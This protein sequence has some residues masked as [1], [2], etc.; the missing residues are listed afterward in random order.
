MGFENLHVTREPRFGNEAVAEVV[1]RRYEEG[2]IDLKK[3]MA[4]KERACGKCLH[5]M[6]GMGKCIRV[7]WSGRGKQTMMGMRMNKERKPTDMM[8]SRP[9]TPSSQ[10]EAQRNESRGE[11]RRTFSA[12]NDPPASPSPHS[13]VAQTL[14]TADEAGMQKHTPDTATLIPVPLTKQQQREL[15]A[16]KKAEKRRLALANSLNLEA[17]E[18]M[19]KFK[20]KLKKETESE[21]Q[22]R[23]KEEAEAA[24]RAEAAAKVKAEKE[25]KAKAEAMA[26]AGAIIDW[27]ENAMEEGS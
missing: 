2:I 8:D 21:T 10:P 3:D 12:A 5:C 11:R 9:S 22:A 1:K 26:T 6:M 18:R 19:D 16:K 4:K 14:E 24:T 15:E 13:E 25:A 17:K 23:A 27:N 20:V 7:D